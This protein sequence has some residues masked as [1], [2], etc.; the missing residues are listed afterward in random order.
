MTYLA[1]EGLSN[2][3]KSIHIRLVLLI[4]RTEKTQE[5]NSNTTTKNF[6]GIL[7]RMRHNN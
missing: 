5:M 6:R 4:I 3:C 2:W 1:L 7:D